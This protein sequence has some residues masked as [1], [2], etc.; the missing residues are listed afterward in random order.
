M[1]YLKLF[2]EFCTDPKVQSMSETDQRRLVMLFGMH[3]EVCPNLYGLDAEAISNNC[4][5]CTYTDKDVA[6]YMRVP[7]NSLMKTKKLFIERRFI[8]DQWN[9]RKWFERQTYVTDEA[10]KKRAQRALLKADSPGTVPEE[11]QDNS[12]LSA[13]TRAVLPSSPVLKSLKRSDPPAPQ[14]GDGRY[15]AG[16]LL[17]DPPRFYHGVRLPQDPRYHPTKENMPRFLAWF[18]TWCEKVSRSL[19]EFSQSDLYASQ[20]TEDEN[21]KAG[22]TGSQEKSC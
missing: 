16:I 5:M 18:P 3:A 2:K 7:L 15:I 9:L 17:S 21:P 20:E 4:L 12:K 8:D 10:K 22:E 11:S 19:A 6:F 14:N 13:P 1:E